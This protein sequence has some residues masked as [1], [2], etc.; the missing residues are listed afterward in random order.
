M[1]IDAYSFP[2]KTQVT[3][4][5]VI[6]SDN[7]TGAKASLST[8]NGNITSD[9]LLGNLTVA[10][11]VTISGIYSGGQQTGTVTTLSTGNTITVGTSGGNQSLR[12]T[13]GAAVTGIIIA[14]GTK[15][16]QE[17]TV[18]H[19]GAAANTITFAA[20]GTSNVADGTSDVITGPSARTFIWDSVTAL[21]YKMA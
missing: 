21:W 6:V 3:G 1:P 11:N 4:P 7:N 20:S 13:A 5:L 17:L 10:G 8:D 15:S 19:E 12:V 16:G 2:D 14:A 9:G 18:I